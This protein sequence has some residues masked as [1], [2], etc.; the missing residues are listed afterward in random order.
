M[1]R[2]VILEPS[3]AGASSDPYLEPRNV[4]H[5]FGLKADAF[6]RR[7]EGNEWVTET[8]HVS[9]CTFG[10]GVEM[11]FREMNIPYVLHLMDY[12]EKPVWY[13]SKFEKPTTP[14]IYFEG[15]GCNGYMG[16]SLDIINVVMAAYPAE[17]AAI[18]SGKSLA[19]EGLSPGQMLG[20]L[21]S[22][23]SHGPA[24]EGSEASKDEGAEVGSA[25]EVTAARQAAWSVCQEQ[26]RPLDE[27]LSRNEY[28][29]GS[30]PGVDDCQRFTLWE[31]FYMLFQLLDMAQ[32]LERELPHVE[33]WRRRMSQRRSN[34]F[35]PLDIQGRA[36]GP[37]WA[38]KLRNRRFPDVK[39]VSL[40]H[41][42]APQ[43]VSNNSFDLEDSEVSSHGDAL[44]AK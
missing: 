13:L 25:E 1:N 27:L 23:V 9:G 8:V 24:E 11:V 37:I 10:L 4:V 33:A 38:E 43:S 17:S 35:H 20:I 36:W 16:E 21:W 41:V 26:L 28:M 34:P 5:L 31:A 39:G 40:I 14:R 22:Y 42:Q 44:L 12:R 29:C 18:G 19:P 32:D 7:A 2:G 3:G 30:V 6:V 15:P